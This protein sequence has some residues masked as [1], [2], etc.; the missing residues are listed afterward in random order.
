MTSP[1]CLPSGAASN[2]TP[3]TKLICESS[4]LGGGASS[5]TGAPCSRVQ[6]DARDVLAA[7]G[8]GGGGGVQGLLEVL[9]EVGFVGGMLSEIGFVGGML[10]DV[11]FIGGRF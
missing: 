6:N 3:G 10:R 4:R 1:K 7:C 9:W 11:G 8:G 2:T 5:T